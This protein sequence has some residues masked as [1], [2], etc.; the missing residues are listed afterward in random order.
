[1]A[2]FDSYDSLCGTLADWL[3]R[4]D[5]TMQI[6]SF[7]AM[8][9]AMFN[10]D[11]R[12][13]TQRGTV[14]ADAVIGTQYAPVPVDYLE[15][16]SLFLPG[17]QFPK[18]E[19]LTQSQINSPEYYNRWGASGTPRY[20]TTVGQQIKLLPTPTMDYT[21]EMT[22]YAMLPP[23]GIVNET[24]WLLAFY[25]NIYLYG[26]L[27][28]AAPFL[29]NDDRLQTWTTLHSDAMEKLHLAD[30]RAKYAGAPLRVRTRG[31]G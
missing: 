14:T 29:K 17:M 27:L 28:Q 2:A 26:S 16:Q 11:M 19:F 9:E 6:P 4:A 13:R 8:A 24:N 10:N 12:G 3:N 15:M 7:I 18:L 25:P 30:E 22:Y 1:M 21:F 20:F 5:L 23:L 31:F